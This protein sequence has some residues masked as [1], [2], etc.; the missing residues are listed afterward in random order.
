MSSSTYT[1]IGDPNLPAYSKMIDESGISASQPGLLDQNY[2]KGTKTLLARL[3]SGERISLEYLSRTKQFTE[4]RYGMSNGIYQKYIDNKQLYHEVT[5]VNDAFLHLADGTNADVVAGRTDLHVFGFDLPTSYTKESNTIL[6]L[7]TWIKI[8]LTSQ[9]KV[10]QTQDY[11]IKSVLK[12]NEAGVDNVS[13]VAKIKGYFTGENVDAYSMP[14]NDITNSVDS[15]SNN[16][17][18]YIVLGLL[19]LVVVIKKKHI[20]N[21]R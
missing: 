15:S 10:Q 4:A 9:Q 11:E 14:I 13:I 21:R 8:P 18:L 1:S 19:V 5:N 6:N 2:Y 17:S 3:Q 12:P 7:P 20:K 16:N